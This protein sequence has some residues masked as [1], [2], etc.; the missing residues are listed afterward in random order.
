MAYRLQ[1]N[2]KSTSS[3]GVPHELMVLGFRG[4][5]ASSGLTG[6]RRTSLVRI[7]CDPRVLAHSCV[8]QNCVNIL[9]GDSAGD[10]EIFIGSYGR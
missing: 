4:V 8:D 9:F 3:D 7:V 6:L 5:S 2:P 1:D 10:E